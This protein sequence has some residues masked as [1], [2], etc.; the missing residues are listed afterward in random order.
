MIVV[1]CC[2]L[3]SI[4]DVW[5]AWLERTLAQGWLSAPLDSAEVIDR[6]SSIEPTGAEL[7]LPMT[8]SSAATHAANASLATTLPSNTTGFA[9][10][11]NLGAASSL[12]FH[13]TAPAAV[14]AAVSIGC[15]SCIMFAR[16]L[17]GLVYDRIGARRFLLLLQ[18]AQ[19]RT[20]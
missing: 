20:N 2:Y 3:R 11:D 13:S 12:S 10:L 1:G 4:P 19:A 9:L 8:W 6:A 16:P 5:Q 18:T 15:T 17:F 14:V 7:P